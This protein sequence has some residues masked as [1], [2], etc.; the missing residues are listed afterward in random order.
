MP[1]RTTGNLKKLKVE[2]QARRENGEK[3]AVQKGA[4]YIIVRKHN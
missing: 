4:L 2:N 1:T 3:D